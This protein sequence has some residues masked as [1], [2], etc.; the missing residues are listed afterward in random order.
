VI[1]DVCGNGPEAASLTALARYTLRSVGGQDVSPSETLGRL[2]KAILEQ[3]TDKRFMTATLM[4]LVADDHG[5]RVSVSNAG[6]PCPLLLR[7]DGRIEEIGTA[8]TL[9]GIWPDP[10]LEN[11]DLTV[12]AGDALVLFTDGLSETRDP[13]ERPLRRVREA[14]GAAAGGRAEEI[15]TSLKRVAL[16]ADDGGTDDVA[17]LVLAATAPDPRERDRDS[18]SVDLEPTPDSP[19]RARAAV[20]PLADA[21]D[22]DTYEDLR[23]LVTELVTNCVRHAG[24]TGR[25]RIRMRALVKAD[26][27][28]V[29]VLD[30]GAGFEPHVSKPVPDQLGGWGLYIVDRLADRWGTRPEADGTAVWLERDLADLA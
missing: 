12:R 23:L 6:H 16:A 20:A 30:P 4:R 3:R 14:L 7:G 28:R 10:R 26:V 17:V 13:A 21:L 2:N 11:D 29:E 18:I 8:G 9:L 25:E 5:Y 24:L 15:C 27:L 22:A 19:A 1:G